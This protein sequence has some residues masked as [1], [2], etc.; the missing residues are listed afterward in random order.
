MPGSFLPG[1]VNPQQESD[2]FA[3]ASVAT[4]GAVGIALV[5]GATLFIAFATNEIFF[6]RAHNYPYG[7]VVF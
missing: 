3:S 6:K 2:S 7:Q 1:T 5:G 4:A